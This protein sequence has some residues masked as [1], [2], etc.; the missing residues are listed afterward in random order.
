M[1]RVVGG[2]WWVVRP[3]LAYLEGLVS[4]EEQRGPGRMHEGNPQLH[5]WLG[6]GS[7]LGLVLQGHRLGV[8]LRVRVRV[9]AGVRLRVRLRGRVRVRCGCAPSAMG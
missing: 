3:Q 1:V 2:G 4:G 9:R 7:G 6:L 8:G 5:A